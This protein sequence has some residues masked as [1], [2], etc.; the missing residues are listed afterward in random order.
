MNNSLYQF[1]VNKKNTHLKSIS[2]TIVHIIHSCNYVFIHHVVFVKLLCND[3]QNKQN[4]NTNKYKLQISC[5]DKRLPHFSS[6]LAG[7]HYL[8]KV[9]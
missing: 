7:L 4:Q 3:L 6:N 9:S 8:W 1:Y 5:L 2:T